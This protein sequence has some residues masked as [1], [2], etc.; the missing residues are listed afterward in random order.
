MIEIKLTTDRNY[1]KTILLNPDITKHMRD[2]SV[3]EDLG[4]SFVSGLERLGGF[5]LKVLQDGKGCG[6]YWLRPTQEGYEAHTALLTS[7]RGK[8]AIKATRMAIKWVFENTETP[9]IS[10]FAWSDSPAV[11]WFCRAVGMSPDKT[12]PWPNTRSGKPV[13]ITYFKINRI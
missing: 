2:D 4:E 7:C 3:P 11:S 13:D 10:S 5:F 6:L 1:I 9:V 12:E 8:D